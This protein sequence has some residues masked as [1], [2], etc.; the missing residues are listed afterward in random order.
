MQGQMQVCVRVHVFAPVHLLAQGL[1]RGP[2]HYWCSRLVNP[3]WPWEFCSSA[4]LTPAQPSTLN[5]GAL[6]FIR[7]GF[8]SSRR[9]VGCMRRCKIWQSLKISDPSSA[10]LKLTHPAHSSRQFSL[11]KCTEWFHQHFREAG[12][13][14]RGSAIGSDFISGHF[15]SYSQMSRL[16]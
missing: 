5:G 15:V 13:L 11:R 4:Q 8:L 9:E 3:C 7:R 6:L 12:R 1:S 14:F 10:L 2:V 16:L